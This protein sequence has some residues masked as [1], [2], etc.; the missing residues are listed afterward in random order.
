MNLNGV[1]F[2]WKE[3]GN[4]DI[5]FIAQDVENVIPIL[6]SSMYK[7]NLKTVK[8]KNMT[9]LI[10]EAIK[11]MYNDGT[12]DRRFTSTE[13]IIAEDNNIDLNYNGNHD[14]S[15]G[16]GIK[17]I[18]GISDENDSEFLTNDKGLFVVKPG[19]QSDCIINVNN[20]TPINS[21]D[22]Y[23]EIGE[24]VWDDDYIYIKT[25]SGWRRSK[26]ETF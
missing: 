4:E 8:Y 16:G 19:I 12:Y 1:I 21:D 23:G 5:G 11:E 18:D 7:S 24:T 3:N 14:T 22:E 15:I 13:S 25:N 6:T 26:L 2:N 9:A 17:I 20:Y 10:V